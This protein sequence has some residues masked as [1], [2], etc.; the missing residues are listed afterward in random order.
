[1]SMRV[2]VQTLRFGTSFNALARRLKFP[3]NACLPCSTFCE[4]RMFGPLF[5]GSDRRI[6]GLIY[7]FMS[8]FSNATGRNAL[9]R[10][11]LKRCK[12]MYVCMYVRI[13]V[14]MYVCMYMIYVCVC[15]C[16]CENSVGLIACG[17]RLDVLVCT[18]TT[19]ISSLF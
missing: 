16:V 1:M 6:L 17:W 8:C 14:C 15:V 11:G 10:W 7:V 3:L 9:Y 12:P 2:R 4:E 18:V 19:L 13:Y 5:A